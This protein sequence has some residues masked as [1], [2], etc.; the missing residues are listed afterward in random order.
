M[1]PVPQGEFSCKCKDVVA[2]EVSANGIRVG[3]G[4]DLTPYVSEVDGVLDKGAI[5]VK[6]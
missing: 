1:P 3:D 2:F 6:D 5:H 4:V